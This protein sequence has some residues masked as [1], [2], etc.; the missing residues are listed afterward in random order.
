MVTFSYL[1]SS[2][3]NYFLGKI[4]ILLENFISEIE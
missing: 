1:E 4:R 3:R 2:S